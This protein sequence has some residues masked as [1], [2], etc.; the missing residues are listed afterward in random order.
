VQELREATKSEAPLRKEP[1]GIVVRHEG[2]PHLAWEVRLETDMSQQG[3]FGEPTQWIGYVDAVSGKLLY[4]YNNIQTAAGPFTGTGTGYYSGAGNVNAWF[5]GATYQLR[6]TTRISAGGPVIR[7]IDEDGASPSEDADGNW[8]IASTSPRHD[9][10]GPEVDAHRYAGNVV[11][12]YRNVHGRNSFNGAGAT[13]NTV[14]HF[15]TDLSNGWWD[16]SKVV[17]G[18]GTGV[19][20]TG[21]DYECSDDWLA[22]EW[23]HAYTEH[24]CGLVF[25]GESGA[26]NEAFSDIMAAFITGDWL[27]FER[28]WLQTSAPAFR[29][30]VDPTNGGNWDPAAPGASLMAGHQP[31][32]YSVRYIGTED[33]GGVHVN[34]GIINNLFY[35]LT[36]GG[37]HTVSAI[38]V[39]GIGQAAAEQ[40]LW[41]CMTVNLVGVQTATFIQFREKM[42]DACLDLFPTDLFK[43]AQIKAAF[44]A[45]GIGP[46]TYVRDNLSDT[47]AEPFP[48]GYLWASPDIINRTSPSPDPATDF[49]NLA[50]DSLWENV[51]FGQDNFVYVRLQ[52]RGA[53]TGD[54]TVNVYFSSASTFGTPASWIRVG[55]TAEAGIAPGTTRI[56]G[57]IT[58][59]SGSI[60]APG[61]YC[62][63]A[64]VSS[65]LDP[66]PDHTLIS[67]VSMYLDY[68]RGT[69]NIAYRNMNVV[70]AVPG[71]GG[72]ATMIVRG[73]GDEIEGW[74]LR[75]DDERFVQGARVVVR[76]PAEV[77]E[78]AV[79]RGLRLIGRENGDAVYELLQ[80]RD[81]RNHFKFHGRD[82]V[83]EQAAPGFERLRMRREWALQIDFEL[84]DGQ[85][86]RLRGRPTLAV[87]QFWKDEPVGA[88]SIRLQLQH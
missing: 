2:R 80:G 66:A 11:D 19:A 5:T 87:R 15:S 45:V 17:L 16:G 13:L 37:T 9:H 72:T 48:G 74:A 61:H 49:A 27:L 29:N 64:V 28:T 44:N 84:P 58:F 53:E 88:N 52:N 20:T 35:L 42:L 4:R 14:V 12:Y 50:D 3:D 69:N 78:A 21:D 68:V 30:M 24:T 60:P 59:P 26:L 56:T 39:S 67:S 63:I 76:G 46:D 7:T 40:L 6:D 33:N 54:A 23:T 62:M 43:L 34:S 10:Q 81:R 41:H 70:D 79:P 32:H 57:P 71:T 36:V 82:P 31:S 38:T 65:A 75:F 18:D 1:E 85:L 55:A 51:E 86:E 73:I 77:L 22:H 47:G 8:N 83:K 25:I